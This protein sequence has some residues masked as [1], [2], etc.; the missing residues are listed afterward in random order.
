MMMMMMARHNLRPNNLH[1]GEVSQ[2]FDEREVGC[3]KGDFF[4]RKSKISP[5]WCDIEQN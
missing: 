4:Y 2:F 3:E 1:V 5:K